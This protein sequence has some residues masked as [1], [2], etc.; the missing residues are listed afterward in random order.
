MKSFR[1]WLALLMAG[2]LLCS[3]LLACDSGSDWEEDDDDDDESESS[4][5]YK[6]LS[7]T[8]LWDAILEAEDFTIVMEGVRKN[9]GETSTAARTV[10]K[11]GDQLKLVNTSTYEDEESRTETAYYDLKENLLYEEEDGQ[12]YCEQGDEDTTLTDLLDDV[13]PVDLLFSKDSYEEDSENDVY[14][15]KPD[16]IREEIDAPEEVDCE[17]KMTSKGSVYTFTF[18]ASDDEHSIEYTVTVK[19]KSDTVKLPDVKPSEN[20]GEAFPDE[21]EW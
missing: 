16:A 10:F 2:L 4:S 15:M 12:W 7:P 17:G 6:N 9:D 14:S 21:D 8:E 19:F 11:N 1:K 18:S 20:E 5:Q 13:F 3:T